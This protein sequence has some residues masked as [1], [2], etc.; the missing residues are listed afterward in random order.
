MDE[1][2]GQLDEAVKRHND[3]ITTL[4]KEHLLLATA[5]SLSLSNIG[6]TSRGWLALWSTPLPFSVASQRSRAWS[7]FPTAAAV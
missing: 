6:A 4:M 1:K 2:L 7:P 5:I 3:A